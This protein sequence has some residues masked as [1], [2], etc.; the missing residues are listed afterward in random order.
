MTVREFVKL[1]H[2]GA[3]FKVKEY[4]PGCMAPGVRDDYIVWADRNVVPEVC[5]DMEVKY[6]DVD[7]KNKITIYVKEA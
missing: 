5:G 1:N 4:K 6:Y 2:S 3:M 7:G